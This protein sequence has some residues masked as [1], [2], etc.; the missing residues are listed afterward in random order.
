[1]RVLTV[2]E[3]IRLRV[4]YGDDGWSEWQDTTDDFETACEKAKAKIRDNGWA[5]W[6]VAK[7]YYDIHDE[8][9]AWDVGCVFDCL[10]CNK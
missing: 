7:F 9:V 1:M 10:N 6:Q 5:V 8:Y 4:R 2:K 3:K